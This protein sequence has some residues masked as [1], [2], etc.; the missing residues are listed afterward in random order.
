LRIR[1]PF[2]ASALPVVLGLL[3]APAAAL[4]LTDITF[5]LCDERGVVIPAGRWNSGPVDAAWDLFVHE[6]EPSK[7]PVRWLNGADNRVRA[8]LEVGTRTY[9]I[10]FESTEALPR[11]GLNLFFDGRGDRPGISAM[12]AVASGGPPYPAFKA[13][14][15]DPTMGPPVADVRAS[16]TLTYGGADAGLWVFAG[17]KESAR[18]TLKD[19]RI[20]APA[21]A[22]DLDLVGPHGASPSG[23]ADHVARIVLEVERYVPRPAD[24][25]LW[26]STACGISLDGPDRSAEWRSRFKPE[27]IAP[28]FSFT[29]AGKPSREVLGGWRAEKARRELD[30]GRIAHT[31]AW[32]DPA[33]G[34]VLK[35]EGV[36][37]RGESTVEWTMWLRN[38]GT[39]PAPLVADLRPL[40]VRLSRRPADE[41]VLHHAKGTFVRRDDYEPLRTV[42]GPGSSQRFAP[43]GGRSCG[44]VFPFYNLEAGGEGIIAAVGWPGQWEARF[45]RDADRSLRFAAGQETTRF[46]L[47]PGEAVRTPL[48]V[49]RFWKG[50]DWIDAQN[51][52]RRWMVKHNIPRQGGKLPPL[53]QFAACSSHQFAEMINANEENQKL[54]VDRYLEEGLKLDY[55][56]MDAGWY[57]NSGGWPHTG[58]WEV[59]R[60]RFPD[61]L[62]AISDHARAKGVKTIVWFEPERVAAD[63]WLT[64]T[65]PE[66]VIGGANGGLLDLG[67]PEA[68]KWLIERVD[69]HIVDEGIDLYRQDFNMDPLGSWRSKDAPDRKGIVENHHVQGYLAYWDELRRRH[70]DMLIDSCASGGHRNDLETMRRSVPLL[71]SDCIFAPVDQ[72]CH[73]Y[74]LALWL[75][76]YGTAFSPPGQ[77]DPYTVR[78]MLCPHNTACFDVRRKDLDYALIRRLVAEWRRIAPFYFGDYYPLTPYSAADD[79]WLGWQFH[80][81]AAGAGVVQAF[82]RAGSQ[83]FGVQLRMRGLEAGARYEVQDLDAKAPAVY[84][85]RD[86]LEKGLR[87]AIEDRPGA[88][89]I[90]YRKAPKD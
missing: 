13:N 70:P 80:D 20:L 62:R 66:W 11:L 61:G 36:E 3:P 74:G 32:T 56:W 5:F 8:P 18:V 12:V 85:G 73:T 34:L 81:P 6:G 15:A 1:N 41:F 42:L 60:K 50:G 19:L 4:D 65:H 16:G 9:T 63:T 25:L 38:G 43:P 76:F 45:E 14:G 88:A 52:W 47:A 2:L 44:W 29:I 54:F 24:P 58:T 37:Y 79:A 82:R 71:R 72:Q 64:R 48:I 17:G 67:I 33:S 46:V 49:L 40:D 68:L 28:P 10:R 89:T 30:A 22:G 26:L 84:T 78:S 59:D 87:V 21:A 39:S 23:K 35:W 55:W 31:L 51:G 7:G 83:F 86:L 57:V 90:V 75:P 77:Y 53:P 27:E 69:R